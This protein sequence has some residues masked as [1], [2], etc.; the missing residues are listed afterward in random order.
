MELNPLFTSSKV[1]RDVGDRAGII[2][3]S[4]AGAC[5]KLSTYQSEY[6]AYLAFIGKSEP[7]SEETQ[8]RFDMGHALEDFIAEQV[9]RIKGITLRRSNFAY[10]NDKY[11]FL[12]CHPDR[13]VVGLQNGKR[14]AAE[15]KSS[16]A[17]DNKRWGPDGSDQIP[18]DYMVQCYLYFI[19][20]V[21][22]EVWLYRFS[23][24]QITEYI[25]QYNEQRALGIM[26]RLVEWVEKVRGGY[27]PECISYKE[28]TQ[29]WNVDTEGDL[30]ADE[31]LE[32]LV[33]KLHDTKDRMKA[34]KN[35]EDDL[36]R[37]I[38]E[39]LGGKQRLM[40][41]GEILATYKQ[42][43]TARFDSAAF[44]KDHADLYEQYTL[45]TPT[46]RFNLKSEKE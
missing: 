15:I 43:M 18:Y 5:L 36:K 29:R 46:M 16:S 31:V 45:R 39:K 10:V 1:K 3:G 25:I 33:M 4:N 14:V 28:A 32:T 24:N 30:E 41:N 26:D 23:N 21:C 11:P 42:N 27:I 37:R 13:M 38:V 22:E 9:M 2:G 19:C 12:L 6:E 8:A 35:E 7:V 20:G 40:L 34:L 44:K 17:F